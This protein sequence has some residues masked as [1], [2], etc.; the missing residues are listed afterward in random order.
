MNALN[1]RAVY[2]PIEEEAEEEKEEGEG[3]KGRK[4]RRKRRRREGCGYELAGAI[5]FEGPFQS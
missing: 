3:E 1:E 2:I 5:L 4:R